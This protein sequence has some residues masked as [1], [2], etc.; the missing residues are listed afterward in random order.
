MYGIVGAGFMRVLVFFFGVF[1]PLAAQR[2]VDRAMELHGLVA[3][4][5]LTCMPRLQIR[6]LGALF[7]HAEL[8]QLATS[9]LTPAGRQETYLG[10]L[11]R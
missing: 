9:A 7:V 8:M 6:E 3:N 1:V 11:R 10:I 5:Q 4:T 2:T